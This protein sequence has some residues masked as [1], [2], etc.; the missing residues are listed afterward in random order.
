MITKELNKLTGAFQ[1][2]HGTSQKEATITSFGSRNY[3]Y[4]IKL[5]NGTQAREVPG[6]VGLQV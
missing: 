6:P 1:E 2:I 4:N 3:L 5:R